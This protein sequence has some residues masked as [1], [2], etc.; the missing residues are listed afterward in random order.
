MSPVDVVGESGGGRFDDSV[1]RERENVRSRDWARFWR[2][3][4]LE[5]C[6]L[7]LAS[8]SESEPRLIASS[9]CLV[10]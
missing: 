8:R 5:I 4:G 7:S 6:S 1:M 3:R 2:E 9:L 10:R